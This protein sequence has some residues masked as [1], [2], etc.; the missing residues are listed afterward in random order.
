MYV[1]FLLLCQGI[2]KGKNPYDSFV[3]PLAFP[4]VQD[5]FLVPEFG[6]WNPA[7]LG[8][9]IRS[10]DR[11]LAPRETFRPV[12]DIRSTNAETIY[13]KFFQR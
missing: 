7:I 13:P 8:T 11:E 9:N 1:G 6:A 3:V 10:R 12:K 2:I 4:L 5:S